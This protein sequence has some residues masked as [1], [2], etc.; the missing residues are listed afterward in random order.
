[1]SETF[2]P[3]ASAGEETFTPL[4]TPQRPTYNPLGLARQFS[5]GMAQTPLDLGLGIPALAGSDW[6]AR[7]YRLGVDAIN[8][9]AGVEDPQWYEDLPGFL[10]REVGSAVVGLPVSAMRR[11]YQLMSTAPAALQAGLRGLE[12]I[13]PLTLPLT[14]GNIA[15]N[16]AGGALVGAGVQELVGTE[17]AARDAE[18][19]RI[20]ELSATERYSAPVPERETFTPVE[21]ETFTPL[22][23]A[24]PRTLAGRIV[25]NPYFG[26]AL[27]G[28]GAGGAGLLAYRGIR[29]DQRL[30]AAQ[31]AQNVVQPGLDPN[32]TVM[33]PSF[34]EGLAQNF[35][36]DATMYNRGIEQMLETGAV[37]PD[38]AAQLSAYARTRFTES[39][40][41]DVI[42][43]ALDIGSLPLTRSRIT[44]SVEFEG[45][46]TRMLPEDQAEFDALMGAANELDNR[47]F[48]AQNGRFTIYN[49]QR[50]PERVNLWDRDDADLAAIV[51]R[52]Q[53]NP[54]I[55]DMVNLY[56]ADADAQL[57][58]MVDVGLKTQADV[59]AMKQA[60]P[61]YM[62]TM[63]N[64]DRIGVSGDRGIM[65]T[66]ESNT[67]TSA[68][69]YSDQS[70]AIR[71]QSPLVSRNEA[72]RKLITEALVNDAM[73]KLARASDRMQGSLNALDKRVFGRV[74][75][76]QAPA[77]DGFAAV[78]FV[79][80]GVSKKLEVSAEALQLMGSVPRATAGIL[81]GA[82]N[83]FRSF[84]TG[85][86]GALLGSFMAQVSAGMAGMAITINKPRVG[87]AGIFDGAIRKVTG[88]RLG[89]PG[90]QTF[91]L[92]VAGQAVADLLAQNSQWIYNAVQRSHMNGGPL[93]KFL[94]PQ[95][96]IDLMRRMDQYYRNSNLAA[97][98]KAG[99]TGT[100]LGYDPTVRYTLQPGQ[101]LRTPEARQA[102]LMPKWEQIRSYEDFVNAAKQFAAKYVTPVQLQHAW[103][104]WT[105]AL[106]IISSSATSAYFKLNRGR[107]GATDSVIAAEARGLAGD[108]SAM[109]A[110]RMWQGTLSA[111]PYSN[112][113]LQSI[114]AAGR[115][116][117]SDPAAFIPGLIIAIT[118]IPLLQVASAIY[119]DMVE[120]ENGR[121]VKYVAHMLMQNGQQVTGDIR[122]YIPGIAPE[123]GMRITPDYTVSP[124]LAATQ[125]MVIRALGADRPEFWT[126]EMAP[127]R[128]AFVDFMSDRTERAL[129][130]SFTNAYSNVAMNPL[131]GAGIQASTGFDISNAL[132]LTGPRISAPRDVGMPG[133]EDRQGSND[134]WPR[135]VR[136]IIRNV[137][138]A[139]AD[140]ILS[141][142]ST[143]MI[144]ALAEGGEP[145]A[146]ALDDMSIRAQGNMRQAAPLFQQQ[147]RL[148]QR[149]AVGDILANKEAKLQS[150]VQGLGDI[151]RPDTVGS[152]NA[153]RMATGVGRQPPPEDIAPYLQEA[154]ALYN[155]GILPRIR[156]QRT[157]LQ[158]D[159]LSIENSPEYAN[160]PQRRL[161]VINER[162]RGIRELNQQ[163]YVQIQAMEADMSRRSGRQIRFD[164]LDPQRGLDQFP[165]LTVQ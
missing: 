115:A 110:S 50:A 94:G 69:T 62:F 129:S 109:G 113:T 159:I 77:R 131:I 150:L 161:E 2:S 87:R 112:I 92:Q 33:R 60:H 73:V 140:T 89:L 42:N 36:D 51:Q 11:G 90:D 138:G 28:A 111:L 20:A 15:L 27:I 29:N 124:L 6:A 68:R 156:E 152:G 26:A 114:A 5:A 34:T 95:G 56:R 88:D 67:P 116:A 135:A 141:A 22:D 144:A 46:Y 147:R 16:A 8:R 7:N 35:V 121:P 164:R 55:Q 155:R 101:Q 44:N 99:G 52:A 30:Q 31:D 106:D 120:Q 158:Q 145:V 153:V 70:G 133:Y 14:R 125:Y 160:N 53:T 21:G 105:Q 58:Y 64:R 86:W 142:V 151:T 80:N 148:V 75:P 48:N 126:P 154:A 102:A 127:L 4:R 139:S 38:Q 41:N 9:V 132:N 47:A 163:M 17:Q 72:W 136:D 19:R 79:E 122:M 146:A 130:E 3:L 45:A 165:T 65:S 97:L 107:G 18:I 98:R 85:A 82:S 24:A 128:E 10:A 57:Q 32:S 71:T 54:R 81:S 39:V 25:G 91:L 12:A 74:I 66:T 103:G 93:A 118:T 157:A 162:I 143:G 104:M 96:T 37:T 43:E 84:T 76:S 137:A 40:R 119:A 59:N 117:K 63:Y 13:T 149:D 61:N 100:G 49:G 23:E 83:A 1:M 123:F 134:P 108:P 78:S